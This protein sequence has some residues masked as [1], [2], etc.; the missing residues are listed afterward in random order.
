MKVVESFDAP[1]GKFPDTFGNIMVL[2]SRN[3]IDLIQSML[4]ETFTELAVV[5]LP[6]LPEMVQDFF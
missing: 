2:D 3:V 1:K 5:L 4:S 6:G